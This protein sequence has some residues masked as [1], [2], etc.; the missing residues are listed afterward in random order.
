MDRTVETRSVFE[1]SHAIPPWELLFRP[2]QDRHTQKCRR[3]RRQWHWIQFS[4]SGEIFW[5]EKKK[6][7]ERKRVQ[8]RYVVIWSQRKDTRRLGY[9]RRWALLGKQFLVHPTL[10]DE[11]PIF[12]PFYPWQKIEF[13]KFREGGKKKKKKKEINNRFVKKSRGNSKTKNKKTTIRT[14]YCIETSTIQQPGWWNQ[15]SVMANR[16]KRLARVWNICCHVV[17]VG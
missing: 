11:R 17:I 13:S 12:P 7:R 16:K 15:N 2:A 4:G 3:Q 5:E 1:K 10:F 9:P 14:G 6:K 8:L